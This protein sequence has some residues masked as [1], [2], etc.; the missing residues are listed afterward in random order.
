MEDLV[1]SALALPNVS[2]DVVSALNAWKLNKED[3][4]QSYVLGKAAVEVLSKQPTNGVFKE[5]I[6]NSDLFGKKS[7]WIVGRQ[8]TAYEIDFDGLDHVLA[9]G[10]NVN[11]LVLDTECYSNTGGQTSKATPMGAVTKFSSAGKR[12]NRK[13]LG[14]MMM[15]YGNVYVASISMGANKQQAVNALME[16]EAYDGPSIVIALCPCINWGIR[17]GM[18]VSMVEAAQAVA[19]GYWPL[20]RYNPNL[21]K[22]GKEPLTIDYKQ[23]NGEMPAFLNGENRYADLTQTMPDVAKTL[24]SE[25]EQNCDSTYKILTKE[26]GG[27]KS[28]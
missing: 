10:Q 26:D 15:V 5:L 2:L 14:R 18:G 25:L 22:D 13:D 17:K 9:S 20:Y 8:R 24:Q 12:T 7:I 4:D 6:E 21:A 28:S 16:A 11:I 19:S 27:S 3:K 23:P 1:N